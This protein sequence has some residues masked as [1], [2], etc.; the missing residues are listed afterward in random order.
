MSTQMGTLTSGGR[1]EASHRVVC[2]DLDV[3]L[4]ASGHH[5]VLAVETEAA[6]GTRQRWTSVRVIGAI[7][8]GARF[9]VEAPPERK[10]RLE[11]GL[12]PI[13]SFV[14]L[15]PDRPVQ[16]RGCAEAGQGPP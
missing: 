12:C 4:G 2:L 16:V 1:I 13:C 8:D 9:V 15:R 5:H 7:R 10:A 3:R 14:T 6:D 11:P